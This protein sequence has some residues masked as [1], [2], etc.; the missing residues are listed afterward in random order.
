MVA[1][2]TATTSVVP[3]LIL[4]RGRGVVLACIFR[5]SVGEREEFFRRGLEL[6]AKFRSALK[7]ALLYG[8]IL[9]LHESLAHLLVVLLEIVDLFLERLESFLL[10][11]AV[12]TLRKAN[13]SPSALKHI[14]R[15][16][17]IGV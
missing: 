15:S 9:E 16:I 13:L 5:H 12:G 6:S 14:V 11:I 1:R 2:V 17:S 7:K 10:P 8:K 4:L 3:V